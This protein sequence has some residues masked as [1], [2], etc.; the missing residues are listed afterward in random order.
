MNRSSVIRLNS[1]MAELEK[2]TV[3]IV[4]PEEYYCVKINFSCGS[5]DKYIDCVVEDP[6]PMFIYYTCDTIML[7]FSCVEDEMET[8][9][10]N[11]KHNLIISK[12]VSLISRKH[13]ASCSAHVV[14]FPTQTNI[15]TY[16]SWNMLQTSYKHMA[17]ISN[18]K[19]KD[20]DFQFRTELEL[21]TILKDQHIKWSD[22]PALLKYG[23]VMKYG[24]KNVTVSEY[25]DA[26]DIKRHLSFLFGC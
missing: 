13:G 16:L 9:Q 25:F 18:G 19:I 14:H 12:Y 1:E 26:R 7:F 6:K 3:T 10:C 22:E 21:A 23:T 20:E 8:H 4:P 2:K 15:F 11:G 5:V 24:A 17:K